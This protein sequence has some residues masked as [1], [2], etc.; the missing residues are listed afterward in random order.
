MYG[1]AAWS[2]RQVPGAS[3]EFGS[4]LHNLHSSTGASAALRRSYQ[5]STKERV[6]R[7]YGYL[8]RTRS[9]PEYHLS[10]FKYAR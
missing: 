10:T 5:I 7:K 1:L 8:P 4:V 9:F 3:T 6:V 2:N